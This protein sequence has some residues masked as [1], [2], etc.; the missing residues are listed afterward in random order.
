M[1]LTAPTLSAILLFLGATSASANCDFGTGRAF[2]PGQDITGHG[3]VTGGGPCQLDFRGLVSRI[4]IRAAP[5]HGALTLTEADLYS[6]APTPG[7]VGPD[8]FRLRICFRPPL[9]NKCTLETDVL[10]VRR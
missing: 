3:I 4:D 10:D 7:Y 8:R 1:R 6:Y 5:A 9:D 2:K